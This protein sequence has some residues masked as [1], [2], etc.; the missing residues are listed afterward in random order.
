[1][2][3][4]LGWSTLSGEER[5]LE[6]ALSQ[7]VKRSGAPSF[8][9]LFATPQYNPHRLLEVLLTF[10][11]SAKVLGCSAEGVVAEN[12]L[13]ARGV[14]ILTLAGDDFQAWTFA[15]PRETGDPYTLGE[16]IGRA[17]LANSCASGSLIILPNPSLEVPSL[18]HGMYNVLGSRFLYLG[19]GTGAFHWT[20]KGVSPGAVSVGVLGRIAFSSS[21]GHGWS[22]S[23]E[24]LVVTKTQGR[25]VVEIDG[26][27][28][29]EAYRERVGDFSRED[30][31]AIAAVHPLGFPNVHGEFLIRDPAYFTPDGTMGFVGASIPSGAVGYIMRGEEET[32]LSA[33]GKVSREAVLGV[34]NP[35]GALLFDCVSRSLLLGTSFEKELRIIKENLGDIPL[36]GFL[37]AG[38][39]HPY[40]RAP[41][42][43]N[44]TVVVAVLGKDKKERPPSLSRDVPTDAEL[45]ILHEISALSFP[46]SYEKFFQ[47]IVGRVVRLFGVQR[48]AFLRRKEK[49]MDLAA[50][51]GFSSLK[52][53]QKV[54]EYPKECQY[55][56]PVGEGGTLGTLFFE[57]LE[58]I[59]TRERRLHTLF[60]RKVEDILHLARHAAEKEQKIQELEYLSLTDELTGLYN[61]RGFL[62]LAEHALLQAQREGK[63]VGILLLDLDNLKWVNDHFGHE[64]GDRV[65]QEFGR[66]VQRVFRKSDIL[67]R[68]GGDEFVA[69]LMGVGD[70]NLKRIL[71]RLR[72]LVEEW[73][74]KTPRPYHLSFSAGWALS[75]P[76]QF[77]KIQELLA[78][79]DENMYSEKRKKKREG[80]LIPL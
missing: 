41:L 8:A 50:S 4:G 5:A 13:L 69:F 35:Y 62:A 46:G 20:E 24:L 16:D 28:P 61:R 68:I 51:W 37:S 52:E 10:V 3:V 67:A 57:T 56:F 48:M 45:A 14:V 76:S 78:S 17:I 71:G 44:K 74:T 55:V 33:A 79:A 21:A 70:T 34:E 53:V 26:I 30:L 66:I 36:A 29:F 64:E 72:R 47:E 19:G 12:E 31:P 58:P 43:W 22:P 59:S 60:A 65:L 54:T 42:F 80:P 6:E 18:L 7:A 23:R 38:E 9:L 32:L 39:I 77:Q 49:G 1:M 75:P 25:E 63:E 15:P 40:G 27:A 2:R 11:P 73:N